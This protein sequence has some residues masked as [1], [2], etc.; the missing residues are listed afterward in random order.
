MEILPN[1]NFDPIADGGIGGLKWATA[2]IRSLNLELIFALALVVAVNVPA[3]RPTF[4]PTGDTF[5][6]FQSFFLEY[7]QL[8]YHHTFIRWCP[9]L[10]YGQPAGAFMP[11]F[12]G[13]LVGALTKV[14]NVLLLF[15]LNVVGLEII[16]VGGVNACAKLIFKERAVVW[17]ICAAAAMFNVWHSEIWWS[18][19][20][21]YLFPWIAYC[22]IRFFV[23]R[24]AA[25]LWL[26]GTLVI[27]WDVTSASYFIPLYLFV[28]SVMF[29]VLFAA[30]PRVT[31]GLKLYS[32]QSI[33]AAV[34]MLVAAVVVGI[35]LIHLPD[36]FTFTAQGRDSHSGKV[37]ISEFMVGSGVLRQADLLINLVSGNLPSLA[38]G[39]YDIAASYYLGMVPLV[40]AITSVVG[41]R[42]PEHFAFFAVAAAVYGLASGGIVAVLIYHFPLMSYF[43]NISLT[44]GIFKVAALF[45][46]GFAVDEMLSLP[47]ER[48]ITLVR[49]TIW[50]LV[51]LTLVNIDLLSGLILQ[52]N[53]LGPLRISC[54][55]A[56]IVFS[57]VAVSYLGIARRESDGLLSNGAKTLIGALLT[58]AV[59]LDLGTFQSVIY[60][61]YPTFPVSMSADLSSLLVRRYPYLPVRT[62]GPT[63]K[64]QQRAMDVVEGPQ[65]TVNYPL[66]VEF[67]GS[68][69]RYC[70]YYIQSVTTRVYSLLKMLSTRDVVVTGW[71]L[72]QKQRLAEMAALDL[73]DPWYSAVVGGSAPK[74]RLL[75]SVVYEASEDNAEKALTKIKDPADIAVI[76]TDSS[77]LPP[78]G[79]RTL[80]T[81]AF[82]NNVSVTAFDTNQLTASVDVAF[83]PGSWLIYDDA[84][85]AGWH[86]TDNG[87]P[88]DI[89]PADLAFKA[90][91]LPTGHHVVHF[92]Y[93]NG[94][95]SRLFD[96]VIGIGI[97]VSACLVVMI[98]LLCLGLWQIDYCP[99]EL[100]I[101]TYASDLY[102]RAHKSTVNFVRREMGRVLKTGV[103]LRKSLRFRQR[104][105]C[106]LDFSRRSVRQRGLSIFIL[107]TVSGAALFISNEY[108]T[109]IPDISVD[110]RPGVVQDTISFS[111]SND[112]TLNT[113]FT[114]SVPNTYVRKLKDFTVTIGAY[115]FDVPATRAVIT[116]DGD[117]TN[118]TM[119]PSVS[120]PRSSIHRFHQY[121]NW[122]GDRNIE[123]FFARSVLAGLGLG[124]KLF[125]LLFGIRWIAGDRR[126]WRKT[127]RVVIWL[128]GTDDS[129][130]RAF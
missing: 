87:K 1:R 70:T 47:K 2:A 110:T 46:A 49:P 103:I 25:F 116:K 11:F 58:A 37:K 59:V 69:Y 17:F 3:F 61:N 66:T 42:R 124:I 74:L 82:Y 34:L 97:T 117:T 50:L 8:Y 35:H 118:Y 57:L 107:C 24:Q 7:S 6:A 54:Y 94:T 13:C 9:N 64:M 68:D 90:V 15:K 96:A 101:P 4:I 95:Q 102:T 75:N 113:G 38:Y 43:H 125:L 73:K 14:H 86:A 111:P 130:L 10:I 128:I 72:S 31:K 91:W 76:Q 126:R 40:L 78:T 100:S 79:G 65:S 77:D 123:Q 27:V 45:C 19:L 129:T 20:I 108:T 109:V 48:L 62:S 52:W 85:S 120:A 63:T 121:I 60:K 23:A 92:W 89:Y 71:T 83:F 21:Y 80:E 36:G 112:A 122:P 93:Y 26:A 18:F 55:A 105:L 114:V 56:G 84:F 99:M 22:L 51:V 12:L 127:L 104:I 53:C 119:P 32:W 39:G 67:S 106:A 30:H 44:L 5:Y 28:T 29:A 98:C 41:M 88:I 115:T 81:S 16:F 33:G